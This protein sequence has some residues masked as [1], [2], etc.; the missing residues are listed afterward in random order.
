MNY[1]Q[2]ICQS[3]IL[4]Q[5]ILFFSCSFEKKRIEEAEYQAPDYI[6][7]KPVWFSGP[8]RFRTLSKELEVPVHPFF[9]L[10]PFW[11]PKS[12]TVSFVMVNNKSSKYYY[13]FD[14]KTG[15]KYLRHKKCQQNDIWKRFRRRL[16]RTPFTE[17]FVPR[18]LDQR[19]M[20]Q[21]IY[22]FGNE[23][24]FQQVEADAYS[25]RV[26]VVGGMVLQYCKY[27]PCRGKRSWRTSLVLIAVNP[28]DPKFKN[29]FQINEL[30]KLVDWNYV[31]AYIENYR[32]RK[33]LASKEYPSYRIIGEIA[34]AKAGQYAFEKGF[35]F[36]IDNMNILRKQCYKLYDYTWGHIEKLRNYAPEKIKI[37]KQKKDPIGF[38]NNNFGTNVIKADIQ[39]IGKFDQKT[40]LD[41]KLDFEGHFNEFYSHLLKN[42]SRQ[43]N[44]CFK[45]VQ[46]SNINDNHE[47]H[48]TFAYIENFFKLHE[49]E[50]SYECGRRVWIDNPIS[51]YGNKEYKEE[52]NN[53]S[54]F[55]FNR[56]MDRGVTRMSV[57]KKRD[58]EHFQ[59]IQYDNKVGGT[60]EK[61]YSWTYRTGK[62]LSCVDAKSIKNKEKYVYQ[63]ANMAED[64]FPL[65]VSWEYFVEDRS[66]DKSILIK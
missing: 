13:N 65:D 44:T 12:S 28:K 9:D 39:D 30:R 25:Q 53:C 38:Y 1:L 36:T 18:L 47:R 14:L 42:Y 63:S 4:L 27:Y 11:L 66:G 34:A 62:N 49:L 15:K 7:G 35:L 50:Q 40:N 32:G 16:D 19:G 31:R 45:F 23:K 55:A 37:K 2:Y 33:V 26:R 22:V 51:I 43:L 54:T 17:G 3:L 29:I 41:K 64:I 8:N 20:P 24:S 56:A 57:L 52:Y 10:K 58:K 6:I 5:V 48:W 60:H 61:I 59:Y 21:K 46:S